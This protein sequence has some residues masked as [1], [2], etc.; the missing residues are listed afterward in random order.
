MSVQLPQ[1][2]EDIVTFLYQVIL[3][4]D[5]DPSGLS[6]YAEKLRKKELTVPDLVRIL[7][8][9]DE[10]KKKREMFR[11]AANLSLYDFLLTIKGTPVYEQ[12]NR[13]AA[14]A[15]R[16]KDKYDDTL[17][18]YQFKPNSLVV[19]N[20]FVNQKDVTVYTT[21]DPMKKLFEANGIQLIDIFDEDK[22]FSECYFIFPSMFDAPGVIVRRMDEICS[23]IYA[24]EMLDYLKARS[25][26]VTMLS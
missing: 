4:R 11:Q 1:K 3:K 8:L 15:L 14:L 26:K 17:F 24:N 20:K 16:I 5:P 21:S 9:S 22:H 7:Y 12:L 18:A 10:N 13:I 6:T 23:V 2:E 19:S 25:E